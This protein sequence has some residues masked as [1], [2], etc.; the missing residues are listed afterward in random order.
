MNE[1]DAAYAEAIAGDIFNMIAAARESGLDLA[2]GFQ[3]EAMSTSRLTL[4]YLFYPRRA[5]ASVPIPAQVRR[6]L[7]RSNVLGMIEMN[8]KPLGIHLLCALG[9]PFDE[10]GDREDVL[11]AIDPQGLAAY[12]DQLRESMTEELRMAERDAAG[13]KGQIH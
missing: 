6:R 10:V 5:L 8:G 4:R 12:A 1:H 3:N 11:A 2:R 7:K 13:R 9:A